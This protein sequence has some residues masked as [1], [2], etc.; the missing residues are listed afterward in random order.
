MICVPDVNDISPGGVFD[1]QDRAGTGKNLTDLDSF[2]NVM[3]NPTSKG[4]TCVYW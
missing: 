4:R 2:F 3:T 1:K